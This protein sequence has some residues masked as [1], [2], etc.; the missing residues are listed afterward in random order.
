M[1]ILLAAL[2]PLGILQMFARL[3]GAWALSVFG[4]LGFA[5]MPIPFFLFFFG[6]RLREGSRYS[7]VSLMGKME[8]RTGS[9]DE[10]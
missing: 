8:M 3:T 7:A 5:F 6:K 9:P 10:C 4:F 2:I 1:R